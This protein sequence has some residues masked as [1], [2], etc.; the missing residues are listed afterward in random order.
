MIIKCVACGNFDVV[1]CG[2]LPNFLADNL[3][4]KLGRSMERGD[5][6]RCRVCTLQFRSPI[7]SQNLL[8]EYYRSIK[9]DG[10]WDYGSSRTEWPRLKQIS[11]Q[12]PNNNVL[13]VGCFR[14]DL[15]EFIGLGWRKYGIEPSVDAAK[16][17]EKKEVKI[18]GSS[19]EDSVIESGQFGLITMIDV[20]EHLRKPVE[21]IRKLVEGLYP[22]GK[23]AISTG[24]TQSFSYRVSGE[25]YYYGAFPEHI[26]FYSPQWFN[27]LAPA[28]GCEVES[29]YRFSHNPATLKRRV[30]ETAINSVYLSYHHLK[31]AP[32]FKQLLPKIPK[33]KNIAGWENCWWTS[34]KDHMLLSLIKH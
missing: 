4:G 6:Y 23:L 3:S 16:V 27:W 17:A 29:V 13:D 5:L 18:I 20:I 34:S 31:R 2:P 10:S 19:I 21:A 1:Y 15:L 14:G 26:T 12:A 30:N 7:P 33:I 22:G 24:N 32:V 11:N 25:R 28:I 8:N 9:S